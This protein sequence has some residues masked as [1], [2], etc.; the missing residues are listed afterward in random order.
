MLSHAYGNYSTAL[1]LQNPSTS[2]TTATIQYYNDFGNP[3]NSQTVTIPKASTVTV[4]Q[5]D[6]AAGLSSSFSGWA[7]ISTSNGQT[8]AGIVVETDPDSG[9]I[10]TVTCSGSPNAQIYIPVIFQNAFGN[11]MTGMQLVNPNATTATVTVNY[12]RN[13][14]TLMQMG[15]GHGN[16]QIAPHSDKTFYHSQQGFPELVTSNNGFVGT[17]IVSS[18]QPLVALVNQAGSV[19][20]VQFNGTFGTITTGAAKVA[21]PTI[22]KNMN[23]FNSGLQVV[24]TST[25]ASTATITFYNKDGSVAYQ[26]KLANADGSPI[27]PG[28]SVDPYQGAETNLLT[29]FDGSAVVSA[30]SAGASLV[31]V[32]N[33]SDGQVFYTYAEPK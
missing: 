12:Y 17:A 13:D 33:I 26:G 10:S 21:L 27:K 22:Y 19:G 28:G 20:S 18:D 5:S 7:S 4:K 31:V 25:V 30:D 8:I 29:G 23:Q 2:D 1:V 6:T 11:F 32:D 14:G 16:F 24:N 15:T 3:A 9:F